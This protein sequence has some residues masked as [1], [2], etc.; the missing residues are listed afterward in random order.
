M[1]NYLHGVETIELNIGPRPIS[2][3][4][5]AVIALVGIA[6]EGPRQTLTLVQTQSDAAQFGAKLPGFNIPKALEAIQR[7]GAGTVIVV[8]VFNP[9]THVDAVT[10][11]KTVTNG[12][13]RTTDAPIIDADASLAL[14]ITDGES[15]DPVTYVEGTDYTVN[16]FGDVT[17][18]PG[19]AISEGDTVE[20]SYSKLDPTAV[21]NADII[22]AI[23]PTTEVRTG[24]KLYELMFSQF[25]FNPRIL[26]APGYSSVKAIAEEMI[27][28]ANFFRGHAIIDSEV[29][30]TPTAALA[31]RGDVTK[32]FGTSSKRAIV[33]Y[34]RLKAYDDYSQADEIAPYSAFLAGVIAATD[35]TDGYWFSPSNREIRG[36]TGLETPITAAVNNPQTQANLLN[37]AGIVTLFNSFGT[38]LR[39]WGNRSAA[40][41]TNTAPSNFI[42]VQRTADILHESLELAM[43]QFIDQPIVPALIDAIRES[44]N[45]F[46][47]TL[48]Q[49]GAIIDGE[50]KYDPAKNPPTQVA[51]GQLVFDIVFMPPTPAERI[52]FESYIDINLLQNLVTANN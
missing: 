20:C 44:V 18:I 27:S 51:A 41:P 48:I 25:G 35:N 17:I 42:P 6:P 7:Q 32:A 38:G 29:G 2:V 19:G 39:T 10:E 50:C 46:V 13:F 12:K 24:F 11:S 31:Q 43:L 8:N 52:T 1:A 5:S 16:K 9:A 47:R 37:E 33:A 23:D 22:G 34:P 36:I 28:K 49:R 40:F 26:I 45:G 21:A 3:V 15:V 4:K 30:V 14:V